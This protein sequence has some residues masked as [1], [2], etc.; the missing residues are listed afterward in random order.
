MVLC[1]IKIGYSINDILYL[2]ETKTANITVNS[3]S[4]EA[5]L[6]KSGVA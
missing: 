3:G 5:F 4:P 2:S 1:Q 6:L